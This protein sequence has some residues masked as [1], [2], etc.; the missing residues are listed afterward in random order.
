MTRDDQIIDI[1]P[2]SHSSSRIGAERMR[3]FRESRTSGAA[4][5]AGDAHREHGGYST[6]GGFQAGERARPMSS[7]LGG[8][9]QMALGI[10]LVAIGIPML[11]LPGPGLLS[12]GAGAVLAARGLKKVTAR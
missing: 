1:T 10:G 11:I 9:G 5:N 8:I 4:R 12:I 2:V 3:E 6:W 7:V